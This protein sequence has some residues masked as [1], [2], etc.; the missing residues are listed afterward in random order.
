[1]STGLDI[2]TN[3][4]GERVRSAHA[5]DMG[6]DVIVA[7]QRLV[8][9]TRLHDVEN[10]AFARQLEQTHKLVVEYCL[11]A[12][13]HLSV[14]FAGKVI[15]VGGQI[16]KGSRSAYEAAMDLGE[17][18]S[19][20][21]GS[22]LAIARD[23]TIK[24]LKAFS[25]ALA[26]AQRG[27]R[28]DAF[29]SPTRKIRLRAVSETARLRG[30]DIEF[31]TVEQKIVRTYASAVV[32]MR[33]F[34]DDLRRGHYV[35]PPKIKRIAQSLVDLSEGK[36]PAFLGVT[37]V[38]NQ[39]HDDAGRAVNTAILAVATARQV[40]SSRAVLSQV[41]MA[42]LMFDS[43][44][45]RAVGQF[46][47]GLP[48]VVP[49]LSEDA[50]DRLPAGAAAVL[51]ALGRVNEPTV[52]RTVVTY[53]ALW[54][55][56][57]EFLGDIYG[58]IREP[59]IHARI[60][61]IA[62]R[63]NDLVTPEPG[64]APPL[65]DLAVAKIFR[66][67]DHPADRTILRM[68]VAALDLFPVGTLVRLSTGETAEV[69][70]GR[71]VG[72]PTNR[73][74]VRVIMDSRG[75]MVNPPRDVDLAQ[76]PPDLQRSTIDRV[77]STDGWARGLELEGVEEVESYEPVSSAPPPG[78]AP[79]PVPSVPS[80]PIPLFEQ[81]TLP[82][83]S[84][85]PSEPS[86]V[87]DSGMSALSAPSAARSLGWHDAP[88][89]IARPPQRDPLRETMPA[90]PLARQPAA[91]APPD[92]HDEEERTV[93]ETSPFAVQDDDDEPEED[94]AGTMFYQ[95]SSLVP[96]VTG[97]QLREHAGIPPTAQG[98]LAKTPLVHVLVYV[99]DRELSGSL[100]VLDPEGREHCVFF[101]RG[102]P[103]K[104]RTEHPVA[105]LG[106]ELIA[107]RM[108]PPAALDAMVRAAQEHGAL[109]GEYLARNRLVTKTALEEALRS[110]VIHRLEW[111]AKLPGDT[112]YEFYRDQNLLASWGGEMTPCEPLG[113]ILSAMRSWN[114]HE[115]IIANLMRLKDSPI[116]LHPK[117]SLHGI[118]LSAEEDGVLTIIRTKQLTLLELYG[119][120]LSV[121]RG[122][123]AFLY[124][125]FATRQLQIQGQDRP[126]MR[127]SL[128]GRPV[129]PLSASQ[130]LSAAQQLDPTLQSADQD[131]DELSYESYPS[132]ATSPSAVAQAVITD[133]KAAIS[134]K[135]DAPPE[136]ALGT[137]SVVPPGLEP[138]ARGKLGGTPLIH[139]LTYM[140]DHQATGTVIFQE[141]DGI[142]HLA[143]FEN[144]G[145]A[146]VRTGRPIAQLGELLVAAGQL[147][148]SKVE[149]AV[150][151]ARDIEA[152]LGE[153]LIVDNL[154]SRGAVIHALENQ[155]S[156]KLVGLANLPDDARYAYYRGTNLLARWAGDDLFPAH[157][158]S[159]ILAV[160]RDWKDR[161]R[162][163]GALH[164]L[165]DQQLRLHP[166]CD[167]ARLATTDAEIAVLN[168]LVGGGLTLRELHS[169]R[170][171]R[172]EDVNSLV[173]ALAITRQF[174]FRKQQKPP[175]RFLGARR[176]QLDPPVSTRPSRPPDTDR[177]ASDPPSSSGMRV[178]FVPAHA[179]AKAPISSRPSEPTPRSQAR[180]LGPLP[181][182]MPPPSRP[183]NPS[184]QTPPS[185]PSN[186]S[187]QTPPSRPSNPGLHV[188]PP[189][190]APEPAPPSRRSHEPPAPPSQRAQEPP[191]P[192]RRS[193]EPPAPSRP[194]REPRSAPPSEASSRPS[195]PTPTPI[196]A[197]SQPSSIRRSIA[198]MPPPAPSLED[199]QRAAQDFQAALDATKRGDLA[200][201][202]RL[203]RQAVEYDSE[204]ADHAALL[205]WVR[206]SAARPNAPNEG[207][208]ALTNLLKKHPRCELALLFRAKLLRRVGKGEMAL[209]DLEQLLAINP[210]HRE[211]QG[212][213]RLL[214]AK[215]RK[216]G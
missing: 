113:A 155:V 133:M 110:Q 140:L 214:R 47:T 37:E 3:D 57:S 32:V 14:M 117:A 175:M 216:N 206:A 201:A 95:R 211:A 68:L 1:L 138:T 193:Y 174:H 28:T 88:P 84:I 127:S 64:L 130:R 122:I 191:A 143:Y 184:F 69:I 139:V 92:D 73:P 17:I 115:R 194:S 212:E 59:T 52:A 29:E 182:P 198:S 66:D 108:L 132:L 114:D 154:S 210:G 98:D 19:W 93:F 141:P 146:K 104:V 58:G 169:R 176:S 96:A 119:N 189:R 195:A 159:L 63:Y 148:P 62:R 160:A 74:R 9:L 207:V 152:L 13:T 179:Q 82:P 112:R 33:R 209:S 197:S 55:R 196:P 109:L 120:T 45:P 81:A 70:P 131:D 77:L 80:Q 61:A 163:R 83:S 27:R 51:T 166:D 46:S 142:T 23:I 60:I 49:R 5:R 106:E 177:R 178:S 158:L 79:V 54:L 11:H 162:I 135:P 71:D 168:A 91:P 67:L 171:A 7:V 22:E 134:F 156:A 172:E 188:P 111:L 190:P 2:V 149:T 36:T 128:Q 157:A 103:A 43:A 10:E 202:E 94:E 44:R 147:S 173:Y 161:R 85:P 170:L 8:R 153:Y 40:T 25:D 24:E 75:G 102:A 15:L 167:L 215:H 99:L 204:V 187:L 100:I 126:P 50:E 34:F 31:L 30:V 124:M 18:L 16:L 56:R 165:I 89:P 208:T 185:R 123:S 145:A 186:P 72:T 6:E 205:S 78:P 181:A 35:L 200:R 101:D 144:G 192:S 48:G 137:D 86:Y 116:Q 125:L 97:A 76:P 87:E 105:M 199:K 107:A 42:A 203:A 90:A 121:D 183:S 164:K 26:A 136:S 21:G 41:A 129:A 39:N 151:T 38:R 150:A 4:A 20:C 65:P 118:T 12:G 53:E 180:P 213:A